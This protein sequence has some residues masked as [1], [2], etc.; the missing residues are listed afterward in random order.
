MTGNDGTDGGDR[1]GDDALRALLAGIDPA[2]PGGPA[3][4]ADPTTEH[5]EERI[6]ATTDQP[7]V[8]EQYDGDTG[9]A[10]RR[11]RRTQWLA[12]AAALVLL[13]AGIVGALVLGGADQ[14]PTPA[15][16]RAVALSVSPG[17]GTATGTCIRFDVSILRDM[18]VAF[19][20]TAT[21]VTDDQVTLSVDRWYR[22]TAAQERAEVVTLAVPGGAASV[23]LDGIAFSKGTQY[24]VAATDGTVNGCG[25]SGPADPQL[26]AAYDEAFGS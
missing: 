15:A 24:L 18:P 26:R 5:V 17:G 4:A 10:R 8:R 22:G 19:A 23:A 11:P 7:T 25:F 14:A 3:F 13:A 12:G 1:R 6:M 20:G 21:A 16:P 2:R 9:A